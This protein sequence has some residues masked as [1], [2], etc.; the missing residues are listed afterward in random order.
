MKETP[1]PTEGD[2]ES[3]NVEECLG[4]TGQDT[5]ESSGPTE[6]EVESPDIQ[7]TYRTQGPQIEKKEANGLDEDSNELKQEESIKNTLGKE[8]YLKRTD[9]EARIQEH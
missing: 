2:V 4:P 3:L 8:Y 7:E 5:V 9:W 1:V 6:G